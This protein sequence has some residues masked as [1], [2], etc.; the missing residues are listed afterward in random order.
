MYIHVRNYHC[1][2][3]KP[4]LLLTPRRLPIKN[5]RTNFQDKILSIMIER[6][7][8]IKGTRH[9]PG[10]PVVLVVGG[11]VVGGSSVHLTPTSSSWKQL[12]APNPLCGQS[13]SLVSLPIQSRLSRK[14]KP[15][16]SPNTP[17]SSNIA[18]GQKRNACHLNMYVRSLSRPWRIMLNWLPINFFFSFIL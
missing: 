11:L 7:L 16:P 2:H 9:P 14:I 18:S 5:F 6:V 13:I 12:L 17:L 8:Y 4:L 1:Y 15:F 3:C 10:V